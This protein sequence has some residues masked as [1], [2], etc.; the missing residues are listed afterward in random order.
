MNGHRERLRKALIVAHANRSLISAYCAFIHD[1]TYSMSIVKKGVVFSTAGLAIMIVA[2]G[3]F[4]P[5][6]FSVANAQA[7]GTVNRA[8]ARLANLTDEERA[9]LEITFREKMEAA[10]EQRKESLAQALVEAQNAPDLRVASA[11]E[12]PIHGFIGRA[13]RAFGLKM[14]RNQN[15]SDEKFAQLPQDVR[16]RMKEH[17]TMHEKFKPVSVLVYT[18][19]EGRLVHLGLNDNDE[20][21]VKFIQPKDGEKPLSHRKGFQWKKSSPHTR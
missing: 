15:D 12:M 3:T 5:S 18:N 7:H 1:I 6:A 11:D 2:A 8:Y 10:R 20:P 4:G 17:L 13:G 14:M 16:E 21:V 19:P 9:A